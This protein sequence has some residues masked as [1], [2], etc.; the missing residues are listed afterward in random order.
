[1]AK[2]TSKKSTKNVAKK[3]ASAGSGKASSG[4]IAPTSAAYPKYVVQF[5]GGSLKSP[6]KVTGPHTFS[7]LQPG[8]GTLTVSLKRNPANPGRPNLSIKFT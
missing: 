7:L 5:S 1:M 4:P 2:K 6:V 8:S 3:K